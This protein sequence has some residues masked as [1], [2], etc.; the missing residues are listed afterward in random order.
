MPTFSRISKERL[1]TCHPDL[2]KIMNLAIQEYDFSILCGHRSEAAQ[3]EAYNTG[4]S[5]LKFPRS[6][7]NKLPSLA[8]D[9]AP[10]PIDWK[11]IQRFNNLAAIILRIAKEQGIRVRWG[12]DFNMDGNKTTSDSWDKPHFELI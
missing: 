12:G 11:N 8:V 2:Q 10:Y 3:N 5:K 6:K 7:H 9:I 4:K 1:A